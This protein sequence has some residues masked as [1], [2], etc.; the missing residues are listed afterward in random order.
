MYELYGDIIFFPIGS[1]EIFFW[2]PMHFLKSS[3]ATTSTLKIFREK[4][5][6]FP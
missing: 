6:T 1:L 2:C 4:F 5:F 3:G